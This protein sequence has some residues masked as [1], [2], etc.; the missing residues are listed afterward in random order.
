MKKSIILAINFCKKSLGQLLSFSIILLISTVLFSSAIVLSRNMSSDYDKKYKELNTANA[1][2]TI[3]SINYSDQLINDINNL[4]HI[5]D[6][7]IKNGI[8]LIVPVEMNGEKQD[9]TQIF[10]KINEINNINQYE[11]VEET[12]DYVENPVY[13]SYYTYVNSNLKIKDKYEFEVNGKKYSFTIKGVISEMLYGNYTSS[14]IGV[15]LTDESYNYLLENNLDKE[16]KTISVISNNSYESYNDI[17]KYLSKNNIS[18]LN[19]NY[20][21]Q[22]KNQRLAISNI[23]VFILIA[24]SSTILLIS[25][26][27]SKFK[28]QNSIDEEMT[29]M[30]VLKSLGYTSKEIIFSIILPYI[31][32]GLIFTLIGISF[33]YLLIPILANVIALQSGFLWN[34]RIDILS[35][36]LVLVINMSLITLFSLVA[37]KKI[38]K[39]NPINAI[40]GIIQNKP[41]KNH[42]KIEKTNGNIHFILMLKNFINTKKQNILLGIVLFFITILGSFVG[43]LFYNIN[44]NPMNFIDTLVEEHPSI[45]ITT[46]SDLKDEINSMDGVKQAIY[47]DEN[48]SVNLS[49]NTYKTFV[50]ESF[51]NLANDLC[52]EGRNPSNESEIA[53]GSAISEKYNLKVGDYITLTKDNKTFEFKIVGLI[54][55]VNYAGEVIEITLDGYKKLDDNYDPK[56]LY[57]YLNNEDD[58]NNFVEVLEEKFGTDITSTVN[59]V[60]S[61]GSA[62]NM[63]VSLISIIC[64]VIIIITILLI[65]LILYVLISSI[66]TKR[67][68]ELGIFKSIGYI[69]KQLILQL[70]GGFMPGTIIAT[71]LGFIISKL[72]MNSIYEFIFKAVG[73]YKISFE[74]PILIFIII[75]I[76]LIISTLL[77]GILL[78]RKIKKISV[79]SL[80]KE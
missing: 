9:Q 33:S 34:S 27:V 17:S 8:M 24:F 18:I 51:D 5:K 57:I 73:A 38:K 58:A 41:V 12:D 61:M 65:Y 80:I 20:D 37:A 4:K 59:Y 29:N 75:V 26:L 14:V 45:V 40:R 55:S 52:Y 19:K 43:I 2:F 3:P 35:N 77:I 44:L 78:S 15:Y 56:S 50:S 1:F 28:I 72:Y 23:L 79:Y 21:E 70:V 16:V 6:I 47:Y 22:A 53:I 30:G 25:L 60:E 32:V 67:K 63:Y 46:E 68:Q 66:I 48:G 39:L 64:I 69:N 42:F 62:V 31:I 76:A 54:Q 11:I 13:L 71:I 10:Y 74:Y 49:D 36:G 7:D